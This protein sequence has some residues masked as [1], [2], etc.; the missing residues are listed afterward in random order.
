MIQ[1]VHARN[2]LICNAITWNAISRRNVIQQEEVSGE[3][4][5]ALE[6]DRAAAQKVSL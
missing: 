2:A 4:A 1:E 5:G 6:R 3:R